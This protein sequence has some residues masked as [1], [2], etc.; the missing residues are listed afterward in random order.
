MSSKDPGLEIVDRLATLLQIDDKW[1][2]HS[3]RGFTWWSYRLAQY[4]EASR[5][6]SINGQSVSLVRVHTDI[7]RE[8]P[9]AAA[10]TAIAGLANSSE[11]LNA[12]VLDPTKKTLSER[13]TALVHAGNLDWMERILGFSAIFQNKAAHS[14]ARPAAEAT[15]ASLA[16]SAHPVSGERPEADGILGV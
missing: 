11:T 16:Q 2:I 1:S 4:I 12:V 6:K 15:K 9:D 10:A 14:R 5:P 3:K 7:L 13:C 8:V